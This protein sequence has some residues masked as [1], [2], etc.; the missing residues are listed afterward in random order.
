MDGAAALCPPAFSEHAHPLCSV[1]ADR[2]SGTRRQVQ[3]NSASEGSPVVY[4][5]RDAL[6]EAVQRLQAIIEQER[7][8]P[9]RPAPKLREGATSPT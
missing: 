2:A 3:R 8:N 9:A 5:H 7:A 1:H 6:E 4:N